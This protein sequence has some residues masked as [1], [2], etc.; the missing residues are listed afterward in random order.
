MARILAVQARATVWVIRTT[1]PGPFT[2][3][4]I[5]KN[6]ATVDHVLWIPRARQQHLHP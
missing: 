1:K 5:D 3:A 6:G 4:A 2:V